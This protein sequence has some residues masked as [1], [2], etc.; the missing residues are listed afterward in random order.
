MKA[1]TRSRWL[2]SL[3]ALLAL[4]LL[5]H[6]SSPDEGSAVIGVAGQALTTED[7]TKVLITITAG[8]GSSHPSFPITQELLKTGGQWK[9]TIGKIPSGAGRIFKAEAFDSGDV[10]LYEGSQN[11]VT[12]TKDQP[13]IV[14]I[15]LQQKTP[16]DPFVNSIPRIDAFTASANAIQP[17]ESVSLAVTASD[18]DNDPLTYAWSAKDGNG[19]PAGT[20]PGGNTGTTATWE[21]PLTEGTY[22]ISVTVSDDKGGSAT[23]SLTVTVAPL[24]GLAN[25]SLDFNTWPVISSLVATPENPIAPSGEVSLNLTA[26]DADGDDLQYAWVSDCG[27]S[28]SS[29]SAE[30]PTWTAPSVAPES[31]LC[32]LTVTVTDHKGGQP[33]GGSNTAEITLEIGS[34][35]PANL[36]PVVTHTFQSSLTVDN[37]G[38][39]TL[40]VEATDP[41]SAALSFSWSASHGSLGT[42][43]HNANDSQ[44][45]W[46]APADVCSPETLAATVTVNIEDADG[47]IT[48]HIFQLS[49]DCP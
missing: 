46:T 43:A 5:V 6:C 17:G 23:T 30:D 41:E 3:F 12:I 4:P 1:K 16:P 24:D 29:T 34:P 33:R 9:G 22:I 47:Q 27:G 20:F 31:G 2:V 21:S 25:L 13:A 18:A 10:L 49:G 14:L 32:K 44:I 48:T 37:N 40:R 38:E 8:T 28:F 11:E 19:D 36:A 7:V 42:P 45:V 26:S 39:V 35:M 15:F